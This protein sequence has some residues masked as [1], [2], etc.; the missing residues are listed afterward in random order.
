MGAPPQF[1]LSDVY[2]EAGMNWMSP[3]EGRTEDIF[4]LA[5]AWLGISSVKR[6]LGEDMIFYS[7]SGVP[8]RSNE[9]VIEAIYHLQVTPWWTLEPDLQIVV[10]PGGGIPPVAGAKPLGNAVISGVRATIKF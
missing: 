4:G 10:N 5:V 2:V 6:R 8:Y 1:N 9:T 3:F 7:G